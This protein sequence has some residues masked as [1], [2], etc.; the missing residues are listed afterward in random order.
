MIVGGALAIVGGWVSEILRARFVSASEQEA[1]DAALRERLD[2]IQRDTL[3]DLQERLGDWMRALGQL[4]Y[5]DVIS[6]R[7]V[8]E[9]R[10]SPENVGDSEFESGRRVMFLTER[11]KDDKLR[12]MLRHFRSET[13][14][15]QASR[16]VN[17]DS[18]P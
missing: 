2:T 7:E 4:H 1:R 13:A 3:L 12:E 5:S 17:H 14:R 11:V 8:G 6:L 18:R 16:A 15:M 9:L 10:A